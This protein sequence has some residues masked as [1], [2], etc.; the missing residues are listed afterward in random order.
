MVNSF[1]G[2]AYVISAPASHLR[3]RESGGRATISRGWGVSREYGVVGVRARCL[4]CLFEV[5]SMVEAR[6]RGYLVV[7]IMSPP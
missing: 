5:G 4:A 7:E 2:A 3:V 1:S 6:C